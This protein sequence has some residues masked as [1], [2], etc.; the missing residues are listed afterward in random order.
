MTI[1]IAVLYLTVILVVLLTDPGMCGVQDPLYDNAAAAVTW[2]LDLAT[3]NQMLRQEISSL[4]E[5]TSRALA[6]AKQAEKGINKSHLLFIL[7][8]C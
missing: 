6:R 8:T 4:T 7:F 3:Q 5:E 2:K 1:I